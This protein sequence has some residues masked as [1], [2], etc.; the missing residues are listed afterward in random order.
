MQE[1]TAY[2]R[3]MDI[4]TPDCGLTLEQYHLL[5]GVL[6]INAGKIARKILSEQKKQATPNSKP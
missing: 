2:K 3:I 6:S 5:I 1:S 4:I